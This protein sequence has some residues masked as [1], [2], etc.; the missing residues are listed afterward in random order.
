M[1]SSFLKHTLHPKTSNK[2]QNIAIAHQVEVKAN[3]Y[4]I[5]LFSQNNLQL[6]RINA[7]GFN[8][9]KKKSGT[10]AELELL[11]NLVRNLPPDRYAP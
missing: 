10:K 7:R 3:E 4:T 8:S 11:M 1:F 9:W 5:T 2:I 6:Y